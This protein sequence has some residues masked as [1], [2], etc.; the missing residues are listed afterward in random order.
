M[1]KCKREKNN[2]DGLKLG[3]P[4]GHNVENVG[5]G[6]WVAISEIDACWGA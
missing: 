6:M 4:N 5:K 2:S 1:Y 3:D